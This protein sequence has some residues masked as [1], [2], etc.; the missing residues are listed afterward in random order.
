M[1]M[2]TKREGGD[3]L[4]TFGGY[5]SFILSAATVTQTALVIRAK[6]KKFLANLGCRGDSSRISPLL[7]CLNYI[8]SRTL[9]PSLSLEWSKH[10][11]LML[12]TPLTS[13]RA[14]RCVN[15]R[16]CLTLG[17]CDWILGGRWCLSTYWKGWKG[18]Q[19]QRW[20]QGQRDDWQEGW[21]EF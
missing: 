6:S 19:Q 9:S 11:L 7:L 20:V 12:L 14:K 16:S 18:Q 10:R 2:G 4:I 15:A 3:R 1:N 5:S 21:Q 8:M 17:I 13:R